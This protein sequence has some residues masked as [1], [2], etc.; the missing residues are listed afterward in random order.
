MPCCM[1]TVTRDSW[2][3]LLTLGDVDSVGTFA[4]YLAS[5][6]GSLHDVELAR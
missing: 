2:Q 4:G 1:R 6:T 3:R 5:L